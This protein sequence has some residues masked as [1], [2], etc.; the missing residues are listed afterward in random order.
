MNKL[1]HYKDNLFASHATMESAIEYV[2]MMANTFTTEN[3]LA[4]VT[5]ARVV[6]NTAIELHKAELAAANA[7]LLELIETQIQKALNGVH[8]SVEFA[9]ETHSRNIAQ[10]IDNAIEDID[11]GSRVQ[12]NFDTDSILADVE[13]MVDD[14]LE[15]AMDNIVESAIDNIDIETKVQDYMESNPIDVKSLLSG[16]CVSITFN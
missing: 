1:S 3:S 14:R 2:S 7:P 10:Q 4:V 15:S 11:W 13:R 12:D 9:L 5:A 6:L 8:S 16:A